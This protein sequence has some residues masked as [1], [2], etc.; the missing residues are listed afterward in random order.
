MDAVKKLEKDLVCGMRIDPKETRQC[1]SLKGRQYFFCSKACR[2]AF[3]KNPGKYV[4]SKGFIGRY[5]DRL[6]RSNEKEF[7]SGGP[8]CCH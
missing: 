2:D 5:L 3:L 7:G 4:K 6:A 8:T 1:A